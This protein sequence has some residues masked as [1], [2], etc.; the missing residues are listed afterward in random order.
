DGIPP[1]VNSRRLRALAVTGAQQSAL[2]PGLPTMIASGLPNFDVVTMQGMFAPAKTP[3]TVVSRLSQEVSRYL[4]MPETKERFLLGGFET[5]GGSPEELAT[6]VNA[7]IAR[8]GK[9]IKDAGIRMQ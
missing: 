7:D 2:M 4:K 8:F 3:Q 1:Q 5:I 6:A 9:L